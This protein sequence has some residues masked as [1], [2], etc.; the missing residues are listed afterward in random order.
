M[1]RSTVGHWLYVAERTNSGSISY[2][3]S[4]LA[5]FHAG[6]W[7]LGGRLIGDESIV[8]Y[9]LELADA[10]YNTYATTTTGIGPDAFA[11]MGPNGSYTGKNI[12]TGDIE[13]YEQHGWYVH[14]GG[15]RYYL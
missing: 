3:S 14:D 9:G 2:I 1:Q 11:F 15:S 12:T 13:F 7:I 6:N 8:K 5:C 4:H 10:C